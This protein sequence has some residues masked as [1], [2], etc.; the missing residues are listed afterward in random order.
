[1]SNL[2]EQ[3]IAEYMENQNTGLFQVEEVEILNFDENGKETHN[4]KWWAVSSKL[5]YEKT[6]ECRNKEVAEELCR[7]MNLLTQDLML[8]QKLPKQLEIDTKNVTPIT[9][10]AIMINN[11]HDKLEE[12][13]NAINH[14]LSCELTYLHNS[15]AWRLKPADIQQ[16]L[17]LTKL[18][19][20]K[21]IQAF[22]EEKLSKEFDL[23]KI[24]KANTALIRQQLGLIEDRISLEKY[25]IRLELKK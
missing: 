1:M 21:Q 7:Q 5:N 16:E 3:D 8:A 22:I 4:G 9:T 13:R 20:E 25:A 14:E 11:K 10:L 12:L 17:E 2:N 24:A 15:N 23:W 6:F 18:P 19:T